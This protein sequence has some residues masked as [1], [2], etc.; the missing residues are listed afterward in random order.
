MDIIIVRHGESEANVRKEFG[1]NET[2][3]SEKG[4]QQAIKTKDYI[5]TL[6]FKKVYVSPLKRA[7]ETMELLGLDGEIRD[8]VREISF[9]EM[10]G[11]TYDIYSEQC[12][13]EVKKWSEDPLNYAVPGGETVKEAYDRIVPFLEELIEKDENAIII[14]HDGTVRIAMSYIFD[15]PD[16]FFRFKADNV[17]ISKITIEDGFKFI[18][19][20][21]KTVY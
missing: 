7:R 5:K 18:N 12:P 9:G 19:F 11:K 21:N 17:S 16:Y 4:R 2:K 10:E 6:D 1:K 8:E 20:M 3:L 14:S 15:N 13:D